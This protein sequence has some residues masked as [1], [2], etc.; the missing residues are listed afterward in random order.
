MRKLILFENGEPR[1][2]LAALKEAAPAELHAIEELQRHL[3]SITGARLPVATLDPPRGNL[4]L[5]GRSARVEKLLGS[6]DWATL[7]EDGILIRTVDNHLILTGG[8]PR[9][10]L[11]AVYEFLERALGCRWVAPDCTVIPHRSTIVLDPLDI[12][13]TPPFRYRDVFLASNLNADWAVRNRL[14]GAYHPL[15]AQHGGKWGYAPM[16]AWRGGKT[17]Y[18]GFVHTFHELVSPERYFSSHPEYFSEVGGARTA[19]L[20]QLCLTN[21]AVADVVTQSC[22]R[23][24][25]AQPDARIVSVSQND[26]NGYCECARCRAV[27]R[28]EGGPSGSLLR[29]VNRIAERLE[30]DFPKVY[31]DTLA[32]MYSVRPPRRTRPRRNVI[33][34]LCHLN[35]PCDSHPLAR[36][37]HNRKFLGQLKRWTEVAPE[38]F[39]WDYFTNFSNYFMPYPNLDAICADIPLYA[40]SGV[41]GL[42]AQCDGRPP[43]GPG[44]MAPLRAYLISRLLWQPELDGHSVID[45]FLNLYYGPAAEPIREYLQMLHQPARRGP[46][47]IHPYMAMATETPFLKSSVMARAARLFDAAARQATGDESIARRVAAARLAVDYTQFCQNQKPYVIRNGRFV[48]VN[49]KAWKQG[50]RFLLTAMTH[51]AEALREANGQPILQE[52]AALNG[53]EAVTLR[54][55]GVTVQIAPSM[56]ARMVGLIDP[57]TGQ[58]WMYHAKPGDLGFPVAGGY[59][60]YTQIHYRSPG[61][62]E[63]YVGQTG[64]SAAT[65]SATVGNNLLLTRVYDLEAVPKEPRLTIQSTLKCGGWHAQSVLLRMHVELEIKSWNR[66]AVRIWGKNGTMQELKPWSNG[67]SS[68]ERDF[69]GAERPAGQWALVRGQRMLTMQFP[70]AITRCLFGW[71]RQAGK[72]YMDLF[73]TPRLLPAQQSLTVRQIWSLTDVSSA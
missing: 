15:E 63:V 25:Q 23:W 61:W 30:K 45:E 12:R 71:D 43:K 59:E 72:I 36:C 42:Y 54:R 57:A 20:G 46:V 13:H 48:P 32:Y 3:Q 29:F 41:T 8:S 34:R 58:D 21:P 49:A 9:G 31:V 17:G 2:W 18:L 38:V 14:N 35:G 51:G 11:Y 33:I 68:G 40:R 4:V 22:R 44:D 66:A 1:A 37:K 5:V 16:D 67:A 39:V 6:F 27:D 62:R 65:F 28:Q 69:T 64:D 56:G 50:R 53:G 47:H 19:D 10:T 24:L 60:E 7:G 26:S 70:E 52:L 55:S 73:E